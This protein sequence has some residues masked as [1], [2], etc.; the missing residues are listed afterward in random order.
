MLQGRDHVIP[1]DIK[2]LADRVLR[3][4]IIMGFEAVAENVG[5]EKV[6]AAIVDSVQT[7]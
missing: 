2:A 5:V 3:H 1:E 6:I 4:R 7:P